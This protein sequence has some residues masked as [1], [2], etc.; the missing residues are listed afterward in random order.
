MKTPK[1]GNKLELM[2][3]KSIL[4]LGDE[5]YGLSVRKDIKAV[6]GIDYSIGAIYTT[7]TRLEKKGFISSRVT[8][9]L[10]VRGGR[11]RR[12]FKITALGKKL[13]VESESLAVRLWGD[14]IGVSV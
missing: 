5:A 12:L 7:L 13:L 4:K 10:P 9:P 3:L 6:H 11:S 1:L 2:A 8:K 14:S